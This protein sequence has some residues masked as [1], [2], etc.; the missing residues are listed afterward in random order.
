[1]SNLTPND[2]HSVWKAGETITYNGLCGPIQEVWEDDKGTVY[3]SFSAPGYND[4][5]ICETDCT[6]G[7]VP[8][9]FPPTLIDTPLNTQAYKIGYNAAPKGQIPAGSFSIYTPDN[10][11]IIWGAKSQR[12]VGLLSTGH[13]T[14]ISYLGAKF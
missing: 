2:T 13:R 8:D 6:S 3:L 14:G 4:E 9:V 12:E 1:M 11:Y 10:Q 5:L 7:G